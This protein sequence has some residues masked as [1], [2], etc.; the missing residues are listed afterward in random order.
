MSRDG[1]CIN[2]L[3]ARSLLGWLGG[4]L[5][6]PL[7]DSLTGV[8]RGWLACWLTVDLAVCILTAYMIGSLAAMWLASLWLIGELIAYRLVGCLADLLAV[9]IG[10]SVALVLVCSLI[11]GRICHMRGEYL[12]DPV[13]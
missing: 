7:A 2:K 10:R 3:F 9:L 6:V 1:Q 5:A 12:P 8:L 4:W 11:V 13:W